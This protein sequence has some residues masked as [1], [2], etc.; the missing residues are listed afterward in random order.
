M[1][2]QGEK[3]TLERIEGKHEIFLNPDMIN[4][5]MEIV[6]GFYKANEADAK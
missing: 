6:S 4:V 2:K 5:I 1:S 3:V